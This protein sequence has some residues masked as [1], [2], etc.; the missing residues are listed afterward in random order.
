MYDET[1][2]NKTAEEIYD[3]IINELR[4]YS[5]LSTLRGYGKG[6]IIGG[7]PK[8][9][10]QASLDDFYKSALQNGLEYH[11]GQQKRGCIPEGLI[12]GI[13]ALSCLR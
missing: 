8:F 2:K 1:L 11:N 4:K 5:K 12:E 13:R 3:Q 9:K 7:S 6:D 10:N